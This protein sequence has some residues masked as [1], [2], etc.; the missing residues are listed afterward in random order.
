MVLDFDAV[1]RGGTVV[2]SG[3]VART[4]IGIRDGRIA[5]LAVGLTAERVIDA[6]G[7]LVLPGGVDTHVH[8]DQP[9]TGPSEMSDDFDTGTASAAAGGTTT[10]VSF[11]WQ[12]RGGSLKE[13]VEDYHRRAAKARIDYS[14][15]LTIT[16][17]TPKVLEEELPP[18]VESGC[19]SV[20]VFMT[21]DGVGLNDAQLIETLAASRKAGA[22]VCV[23]AEHHGLIEYLSKRLV[24]AGLT[25]PKYHPWA[26]PALVEREAIGR[27]AAIAEM[28]DVPIQIF[29]VSC[30]ETAAEVARFRAQG[31]KIWAETCPQ[32]LAFTAEDLDR[33]GFEGAK[34]IFGPPARSAS[35][36]EG[37]WHYLR[38]GTLGIIS[39]DHSP[40]NFDSPRGKKVAGEDASFDQV[41]NGIPGLAARLPIAFHE[42]V[43]KG[44]IDLETFVDLVATRPARLFGLA[45]RKGAIA[46]G[47]DADLV[48]WDPDATQVLTLAGQHHGGD[49]TPYEGREVRGRVVSTYLRGEA[50]FANGRVIGPPGEG[51][52]LARGPYPEIAPRGVFPIPFNPVDGTLVV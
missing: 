37:L 2:T 48:L 1:I 12:P 14:F 23:H 21:Y 29:H 24:A 44:R 34:F 39:S 52:F 11:A 19:R 18:L 40:M 46:I 8:L 28:L 50:V 30:P 45:P 10:I 13:T 20:K 5:A 36:T 7:L 9:G 31:L 4:D 26:K 3:G 51:R 17:P 49:Y 32:Y 25:A 27:I 43:V 42:G 38:D 15:H 16:D 33:P 35:D 47:A 22:L 6:G 41:P